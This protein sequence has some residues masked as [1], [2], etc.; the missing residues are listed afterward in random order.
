MLKLVLF[1]F[2]G[3]LVDSM[4]YYADL[5][6]NLLSQHYSLSHADARKCYLQTSGIAFT[7]QLE[8]LF[9]QHPDNK[10]VE[11]LFES[12]KVSIKKQINWHPHT[13]DLL[14]LLQQNGYQIGISSSEHEANIQQFMQQKNIHWDVFLG[15][16]DASFT[17]GKAHFS[18][19]LKHHNLKPENLLFIGDSLQD[20]KICAESGVP[21]VAYL[22]T[23]SEADFLQLHKKIPAYTDFSLLGK[24]LL[25]ANLFQRAQHA[26]K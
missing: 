11:E 12:G 13:I 20:Y 18:Y 5:A 14:S 9:P 3:T 4:T 8:S 24:D 22:S 21:F 6:A 19:L 2:D 1:D 16:R 7:K 15:T 10:Q 23:F 17:K 25:S 26:V